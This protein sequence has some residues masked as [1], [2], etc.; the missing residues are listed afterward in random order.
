MCS[1][2]TSRTPCGSSAAT[3]SSSPSC[4]RVTRGTTGCAT[5]SGTCATA[6]ASVRATKGCD[7]IIHTAAL[8]QVSTTCSRLF[9]R[10]SSAPRTSSRRPG[11]DNEVPHTIQLSTDKAVNPVNL[12]G[13]TKL[14]AE[15]IV[16]QG[17]AYAADSVARFANVRYGNVVGS[18][19][20]VVPIFVGQAGVA[21]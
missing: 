19:G 16:T 7:V 15:K 6:T 20:S 8:K 13:A 9:R 4:R 18:R 5:S 12:Y 14:A 3:S 21:S 10:T 2:S 1:G 11:I 17:N